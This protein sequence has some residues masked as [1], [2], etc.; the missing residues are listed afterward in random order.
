MTFETLD[1]DFDTLA[2]R[3]REMAY[4][5]KAVRIRFTDRRASPV[6]RQMSYYF[7]SGVEAFVRHINREK[8]PVHAIPIYINEER[9]GYW[10]R[11]P[12]STTRR[13]VSPSTPSRTASRR[14]MGAPT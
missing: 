2:N 3:F 5:T 1:Y 14:S 11:S 4:L 9:D 10:S 13:S 7:D 6:P 12:S 8:A